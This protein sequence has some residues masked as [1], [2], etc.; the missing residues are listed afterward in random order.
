MTASVTAAMHPSLPRMFLGC[1]AAV[2]SMTART[3]AMRAMHPSVAV[4]LGRRKAA[5]G[6]S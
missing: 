2:T 1:I 4:A 6:P 3:A 5:Y